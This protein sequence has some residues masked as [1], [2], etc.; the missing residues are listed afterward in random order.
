MVKIIWALCLTIV[1]PFGFLPVARAQVVENFSDGNFSVNPKWEGDASDFSVEM[2]WLR[3]Q[4][5]AQGGQSY[6]STP[7]EAIQ[8]AAWEFLVHMAFNPS[9][10]NYARVYVSSDKPD[11]T[12]PLDG[13]YVL[14]GGASDEV[15]LYRQDG[16]TS[17][18]I[19][20]GIDGTTDTSQVELRVRV[21]RNA[22]GN[23]E[24]YTAG[25]TGQGFVLQGEGLD[26]THVSS[27]YFGIFCRYTSTR[28]DGFRFD[29]I[30][31]TGEPYA[32]RGSQPPYKGV[33]ITEILADPL[34]SEGLP[35]VE[36][37]EIYNRGTE[38][39]S[40]AGGT[41]SDG[42][43]AAVLPAVALEPGD[44]LVVTSAA[45][46]GQFGNSVRIAAVE[47][48]PAL[49][50]TGDVIVLRSRDGT[51][52]DSVNYSIGWYGSAD[53]ADGGWSLE[54][55]DPDHVCG[56]EGNWTASQDPSGGT[57]GRQN[58]VYGSKPDQTGPEIVQAVAIDS[59]LV[60]IF[61][62]EKLANEPVLPQDI[63]FDPGVTVSG[64]SFADQSL[65]VV[66]VVL[67]DKL[68]L[69]TLYSVQVKRVRDCSRN[70]VTDEA[71][72][73]QFA[74]PETADSLDVVINELLVN[75]KPGGVDF[76]E[77]YNCSPKFINIEQWKIG[78][79]SGGVPENTRALAPN[80]VLLKPGD[81]VV[82]TTDPEALMNAH[83]MA[84]AERIL[85]VTL[86]SLPDDSGSV[87]L[88]SGEGKVI[89]AVV[90]SS[91]WHSAFLITE[92][93]VSLERVSPEA[94]SMNPQNW[95]SGSTAAGFSSPGK[96]NSSARKGIM[97]G[98]NAVIIDPPVF[99]PMSGLGFT[100][101]RY[102]FDQG[103]HVANARILD[104][105]GRTIKLLADNDLLGREGFY[106]WEGDR[107]D[108][109]RARIGSYWVWF[110]LYSSSGRV[111]TFRE[112]I[113]IAGDF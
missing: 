33:I 107:D 18:K 89:D 104:A 11:L 45:G 113:V 70:L 53:R 74:I 6:L 67:A 14:V 19:I 48:M 75:P 20:D 56:E 5:P 79:F 82:L 35:E 4:A 97:P 55:I 61:F 41:I 16:N 86:P 111:M 13:Y 76:V 15:S 32:A 85:Q 23:W 83:P 47:G 77:L 42:S 101:I 108:G 46:S 87:A 105:S 28:S 44:Y 12:G 17:V 34:P 24:L 94:G 99:Q 90:Y 112:R 110:E 7:S 8:N 30:S 68:T 58:S 71:G 2:E 54:L 81:Y 88:V 3:L 103:G 91:D 37:I 78:G 49:N 22:N 9:G 63:V 29:D 1:N 43:A 93:G 27:S 73:T 96:E 64:V 57:P 109:S 100:L 21:T 95:N 98:D 66:D 92:D 36:Y 72:A 25:M 50:N 59:S 84:P 10:Q 62:N 39:Y 31:V 40:L 26:L 106:T 65:R 60:R 80:K 69:R 102:K 52:I 38:S 51:V